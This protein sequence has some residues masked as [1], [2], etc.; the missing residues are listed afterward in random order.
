M[1]ATLH[2]SIG[3]RNPTRILGSVVGHEVGD[4]ALLAGHGGRAVGGA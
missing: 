4:L 3:S 2:C 1:A